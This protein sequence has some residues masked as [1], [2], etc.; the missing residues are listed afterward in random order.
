[1]TWPCHSGSGSHARMYRCPHVH[2][3]QSPLSAPECSSRRNSD[4]KSSSV[5]CLSTFESALFFPTVGAL[6][7]SFSGARKCGTP[8]T[9]GRV[10]RKK[11]AFSG[12][13]GGSIGLFRSCQRGR[14]EDQTH[15]PAWE[16]GSRFSNRNFLYSQGCAR[17]R[18]KR[19]FVFVSFKCEVQKQ[20]KSL[21]LFKGTS[22]LKAGRG[23]KRRR[24]SNAHVGTLY[25][26]DN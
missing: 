22:V 11:G 1:M 9:L 26:A 5:L 17:R 3:L 20:K 14:S 24:V 19:Y 2:Y 13:F 23:S 25:R 10:G 4:R 7:S 8:E 18:A 15:G 6:S 21:Y 16:G 12:F